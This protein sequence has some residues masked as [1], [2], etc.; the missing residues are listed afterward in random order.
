V[1]IYYEDDDDMPR[2]INRNLEEDWKQLASKASVA[3]KDDVED[4]SW[5]HTRRREDWEDEKEKKKL[6]KPSM[7]RSADDAVN[8]HIFHNFPIGKTPKF[9][10]SPPSEM[11]P[12]NHYL[13]PVVLVYEE[14][15]DDGLAF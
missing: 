9:T 10:L 8:G 4:D 3:N 14:R 2:N 15:R 6:Q 7:S 13:L 1:S 12:Q 11:R 5:L